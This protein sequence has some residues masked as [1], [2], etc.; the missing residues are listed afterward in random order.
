MNLR[1]VLVFVLSMVLLGSVS[2]SVHA[3]YWA[4]T[5]TWGGIT[6]YN[7]DSS[8]STY[9]YSTIYDDARTNWTGISSGVAFSNG[10]H[11]NADKYYVGI[12]SSPT[13]LGQI[14]PYDGSGNSTSLTGSWHHVNVS[15]YDNTMDNYNMSRAERVGNATHEV[16]HS[17]KLAHPGSVNPLPSPVT[18]IMNQGIQ[19]IAPT[20]YD[21]Q[22]LKATWGN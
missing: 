21:K 12:T 22:E 19:S 13:L 14:I 16:G 7:Y 4:G 11:T 1:K 3:D 8:V 9:G 15:I 5:K 6:V 17:L 2:M 18:S 10:T 20:S